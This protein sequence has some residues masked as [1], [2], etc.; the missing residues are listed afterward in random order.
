[1]IDNVDLLEIKKALARKDFFSYCNLKAPSFYKEDRLYLKNICFQL[2]DF[3]ESD[4][5]VLILKAPPRHGWI[6]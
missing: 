5:D 1:M 3:Y 6:Y 4:D 2:Q